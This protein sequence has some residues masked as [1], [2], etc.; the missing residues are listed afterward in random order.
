MGLGAEGVG[1]NGYRHSLHTTISKH[2]FCKD[3]VAILLT[4]LNILHY[5][6]IL[7]K[8]EGKYKGVIWPHPKTLPSILQKSMTRLASYTHRSSFFF[9]SK[10]DWP[11]QFWNPQKMI[12]TLCTTS[13]NLF[14]SQLLFTPSDTKFLKDILT[15][16]PK[17]EYP[18]LH[19]FR[20]LSFAKHWQIRLQCEPDFLKLW[21]PG[22]SYNYWSSATV[23]WWWKTGPLCCTLL[24]L[25]S[26]WNEVSSE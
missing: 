24:G 25:F 1:W 13:C 15:I 3:F 22:H 26:F 21:I 12:A 20:T 10:L 23:V 2:S 16:I 9:A 18:L 14:F 11:T 17:R 7:S 19:Y 4:N 5:D 6:Q 8:Q